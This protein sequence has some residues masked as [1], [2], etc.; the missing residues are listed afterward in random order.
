MESIRYAHIIPSSLYRT[1][2][3]LH[4][5]AVIF[6]IISFAYR[7]TSARTDGYENYI[8]EFST[9]SGTLHLLGIACLTEP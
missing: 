7:V 8:Y 6:F 1:I 2:D 3:P 5:S 9:V 4:K